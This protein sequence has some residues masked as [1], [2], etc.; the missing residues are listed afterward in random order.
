MVE[1]DF[2]STLFLF[3]YG[4]GQKYKR[5]V[6]TKKCKGLANRTS[7]LSRKQIF[8]HAT[9]SILAPGIHGLI[10]SDY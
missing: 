9:T 8:A 10:Y 2:I 7:I 3:T 6:C 1:R 5:V 4:K